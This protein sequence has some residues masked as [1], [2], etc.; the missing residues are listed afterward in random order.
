MAAVVPNTERVFILQ[1]LKLSFQVLTAVRVFIVQNVQVQAVVPNTE[2]VFILQV[3]KQAVVPNTER[4]FILQVL[5][6]N[7]YL[8]SR[9]SSCHS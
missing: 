8:F 9:F 6:L 4:V 3:L 2:R 1:V 5:K 7:V